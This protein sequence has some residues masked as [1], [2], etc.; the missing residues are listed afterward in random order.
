VAL[1]LPFAATALTL[2]VATA[3]AVLAVLAGLLA[4]RIPHEQPATDTL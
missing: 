2:V 1:R 3:L 4:R